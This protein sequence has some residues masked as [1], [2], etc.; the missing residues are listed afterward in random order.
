MFFSRKSLD[1]PGPADVSTH[2]RLEQPA[3]GGHVG[4]VSGSW[5]GRLD[6]LPRRLVRFFTEFT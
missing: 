5:P 3:E 6:W 4:F 2:V 1:L